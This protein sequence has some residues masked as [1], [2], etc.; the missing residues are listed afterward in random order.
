MFGIWVSWSSKMGH[1]AMPSFK[2]GLTTDSDHVP[3]TA[4]GFIALPWSRHAR[5]IV[6]TAVEL[7]AVICTS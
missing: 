5:R 6:G 7:G 4:V 2:S 1:A 3:P